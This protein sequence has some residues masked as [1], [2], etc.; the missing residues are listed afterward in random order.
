[1]ENIIPS[2]LQANYVWAVE[3]L[4]LTIALSAEPWSLNTALHLITQLL[5]SKLKTSCL[6][7]PFGLDGVM[8]ETLL[9]HAV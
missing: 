8:E 5:L 3:S 1:M 4:A 7:K 9:H 6:N 2:F